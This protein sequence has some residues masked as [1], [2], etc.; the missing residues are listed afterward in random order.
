MLSRLATALY[1]LCIC[2]WVGGLLAIGL[3][4]APA[5]FAYIPDRSYAGGLA[6]ALFAILGWVGL[7]CGGY[8]LLYLTQGSRGRG[9]RSALVWIVVAMLLITAIGQFG[10][11][12][13]LAQMRSAALPLQVMESPLR[14]S[15]AL[16]HGISGVLYLLQAV[17]GVWLVVI[18]ER[19]R[20]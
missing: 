3:L 7:A 14:Q 18:Q 15:F 6:G 11:H 9:T 17:L 4:A 5:L 16:W 12:P 20:R 13:M 10:I 1:S 8:L 2:V 19:G